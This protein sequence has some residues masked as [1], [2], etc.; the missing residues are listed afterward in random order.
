MEK[1][2]KIISIYLL[3]I[4]LSMSVLANGQNVCQNQKNSINILND[5]TL[6]LLDNGT[7]VVFIHNDKYGCRSQEMMKW[8]EMLK[9]P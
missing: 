6:S 3:F 9:A 4:T 2:F 1:K 8:E 7:H 5:N